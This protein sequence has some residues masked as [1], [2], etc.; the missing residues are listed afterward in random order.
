MS[1]SVCLPPSFV[2]DLRIPVVSTMG[3]EIEQEGE[4]DVVEL[5]E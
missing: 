5:V 3:S 4:G 1:Q 2:R